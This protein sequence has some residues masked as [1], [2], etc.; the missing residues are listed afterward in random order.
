VAYIEDKN[1]VRR[2][3]KWKRVRDWLFMNG[4]ETKNKG[5]K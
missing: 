5:V 3:A 4:D 2:R 1:F